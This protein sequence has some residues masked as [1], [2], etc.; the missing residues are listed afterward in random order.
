MGEHPQPLKCAIVGSGIAGLTA[1]H[2]LSRLGANVVFFER[3]DS[4]GMAAFGLDVK[5]ESGGT[6]RVDVPLRVFSR[7]Y[8][9]NLVKLYESI[10][11][12]IVD[13]DYSFSCSFIPSQSHPHHFQYYRWGWLVLPSLSVMW[14]FGA[15]YLYELVRLLM[16]AKSLAK[17]SKG[18]TLR[19]F[20]LSEGFTE[21]FLTDVFFPMFSVVAT[22]SYD[23]VAAYPADIVLQVCP[24]VPMS[25]ESF[26]LCSTSLR[27]EY[28]IGLGDRGLASVEWREVS[29]RLRG[30]CRSR[31]RGCI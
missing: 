28:S 30:S 13:A 18:T 16:S 19:A 24:P 21:G 22:C 12:K 29:P 7:T 11:A 10:G 27:T 4:L 15:G 9:P 1:G 2:L 3:E 6:R 5:S 14:K 26:A 31:R 23:S 20:L 8:Y 25:S 17:R